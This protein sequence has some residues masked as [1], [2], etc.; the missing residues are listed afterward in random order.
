[1]IAAIGYLTRTAPVGHA[2]HAGDA[3]VR[4]ILVIRVDLIGDVV[5]SL[6]AVRALKRAYPEAE[7]D[8]LALKSSA[9]ILASEP[10]ITRILTFDPYFWRRRLGMFS[11]ATWRDA[12]VFLRELRRQHYDVALSISGDIASI[13]ARLSGA[14][15]RVGYAAEAYPHLLT[16]PVHGGRYRVRQHEVQYVL[17]L[18]RAAGAHVTPADAQLSLRVDRVA[19]EQVADMVNGARAR[20]GK[21]G[22]LVTL[23]PGARNGQAKRWPEAH[24]AAL[25][26]R[27]AQ[28]RD[29]LVVLTGAPGEAALAETVERQ[30]RG[31]VANLCG[32]TSLP[33]LAALLAAS[34]L[35]ISGDSGPMHIA[36][37]VGTP[38]VALHGP[39]D[40]AISGP[41]APRA[42]VL[43]VPLWCAPCYDASAT[44][45]CRFGNPVCMKSLSP[46]LVF[47]AAIRQLQPA[48]V[49]REPAAQVISG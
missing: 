5:L 3:R 11:P 25:A 1:M 42:I 33:E 27:L 13:L 10:E 4:R 18:A 16:D 40:P 2:L 20:L 28:E 35:V 30:C 45:E 21:S 12:L 26:W 31:Q 43:R 36:C 6:P 44:A 19:S 23:H 9:G 41:T 32:K 39:T 29:A 48:S 38:V 22:P 15:R 7:I 14:T 37:A 8:F 47:A 49:I 24:I 46:D 34:D 17:A